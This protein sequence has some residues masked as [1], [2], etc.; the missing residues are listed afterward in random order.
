MTCSINTVFQTVL[1]VL[2]FEMPID[3][4]IEVMKIH[5]QWFPDE[6]VFEKDML[7]PDTQKALEQMGH[8]TKSRSRLGVLMGI[9]YDPENKIITGAADSIHPDGGAVGY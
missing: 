8:K 5:H 3:R 9:T 4:A 2:E 6:I 7:S 1:N